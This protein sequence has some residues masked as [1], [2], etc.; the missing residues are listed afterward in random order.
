MTSKCLTTVQPKT[1][2]PAGNLNPARRSPLTDPTL[3]PVTR[4]R[5]SA[6][7]TAQVKRIAAGSVRYKATS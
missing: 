1:N 5:Q 7:F 3:D 4:A 2:H 6:E